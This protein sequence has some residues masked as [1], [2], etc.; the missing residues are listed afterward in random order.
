MKVSS[1]A[2]QF[3]GQELLAYAPSYQKS[4]LYYWQRDKR[5]SQAEVD[6]V[7]TVGSKIIPLEVKAGK[8]GRLR[9]MQIFLDERNYDLGIRV[10]QSQ[11]SLEKR[12]LSIPL[13]LIHEIPRLIEGLI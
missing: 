8:T 12:I 9:S 4:Q 5:G 13:Y 6:Y 7:I 1:L 2:E 10:S 3:V 11:L